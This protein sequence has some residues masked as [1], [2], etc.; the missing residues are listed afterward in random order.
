MLAFPLAA[1]VAASR[2]AHADGCLGA[3]RPARP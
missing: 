3:R 1:V 2:G